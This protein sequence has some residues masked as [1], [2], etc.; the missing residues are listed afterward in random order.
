M[1]RFVYGK[2]KKYISPKSEEKNLLAPLFSLSGGLELVDYCLELYSFLRFLFFSFDLDS[3]EDV[4]EDYADFSEFHEEMRRWEAELQRGG[5]DRKLRET[6]RRGHAE[7]SRHIR[8]KGYV[9]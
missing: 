2:R 5:N 6:L 1:P 8:K 9:S 3:T 4:V 7:V